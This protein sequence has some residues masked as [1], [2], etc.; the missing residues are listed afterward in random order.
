MREKLWQEQGVFVLAPPHPKQAKKV[1]S[2]WQKTLLQAR[3]RVES[4]FDILKEHLHLVSSFPRSVL[5]FLFH[6]LRILLAYQL[7]KALS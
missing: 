1:M 7:T 2:Q 3:P 5:G 6:Y 4:V